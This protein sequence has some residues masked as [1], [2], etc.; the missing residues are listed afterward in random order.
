MTG[1]ELVAQ[2]RTEDISR[3]AELYT[4]Q[5]ELLERRPGARLEAAE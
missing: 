5:K 4:R 1:S 3:E 2:G